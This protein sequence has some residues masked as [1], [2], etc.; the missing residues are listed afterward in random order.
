METPVV[1][2]IAFTAGVATVWVVGRIYRERIRSSIAN[3]V[4]GKLVTSISTIIP[5][6]PISITPD[7]TNAISANVSYPVADGVLQGLGLS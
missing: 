3:S 4:T 2:A 6:A 1:A 5:G 7:M